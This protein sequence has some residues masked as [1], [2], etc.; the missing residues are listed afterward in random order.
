M[1]RPP[2]AIPPLTREG[3]QTLLGKTFRVPHA[4]RLRKTR[5]FGRVWLVKVIRLDWSGEDDAVFTIKPRRYFKHRPRV[6]LNTF[7]FDDEDPFLASIRR[8]RFLAKIK[9]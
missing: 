9:L 6:A 8:A 7:V 4:G 3:L 5:N 1:K 2:G